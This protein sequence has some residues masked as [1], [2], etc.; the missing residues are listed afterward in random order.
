M[1]TLNKLYV[2]YNFP[3]GPKLYQIARKNFVKTTRVDVDKFVNSQRVSELFSTKKNNIQGKFFAFEPGHCQVDLIDFS[4]YKEDNEDYSWL[5]VLIDLYSRRAFGEAIKSKTADDVL[6][7]LFKIAKKIKIIRLMSDNGVEFTNKKANAFYETNNI[8]HV[9]NDVNDHKKLA[10]IDRYC[11]TI[12]MSLGK[13]FTYH[14]DTDWIHN[15]KSVIDTYNNSPHASLHDITPNESKDHKNMLDTMNMNIWLDQ[16]KNPFQVGDNVRT[17]KDNTFKKSMNVNWSEK[18]Y[19]VS[20]VLGLRCKLEDGK[21]YSINELLKSDK[22][23]DNTNEFDETA[24]NRRKTL[25]VVTKDVK[26]KKLNEINEIFGHK[27]MSKKLFLDV[28]Y[29]NDLQ[30]SLQPLPNFIFN[31]LVIKD[32]DEYLTKHKLRKYIN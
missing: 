11:R 25:R 19:K 18:T 4:K 16:V 7:A 5:L 14:N 30:R 29:K 20:E 6:D 8:N 27:I 2:K 3:S 24:V 22:V 12:K 15:Y 26:Q 23:D 1:N 17:I 21:W 31:G 9:T 10:V 13:L 32:V 28:N